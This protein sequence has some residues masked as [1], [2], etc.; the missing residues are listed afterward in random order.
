[1]DTLETLTYAVT[2]RIARITLNRPQRA[3]AI[4]L[5]H[6]ARAR[7]SLWSAPTSTPPST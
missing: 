7:G 4:T 6:A 1:M 2:G 5:R 3:N